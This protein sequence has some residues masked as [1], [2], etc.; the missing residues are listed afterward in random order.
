MVCEGGE[1]DGEIQSVHESGKTNGGSAA[2]IVVAGEP[3]S[4]QIK[5]GG[6]DRRCLPLKS[7][8]HQK[9]RTLCAR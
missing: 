7:P 5:R 4:T 6:M 1:N 2:Q 3:E 8:R 9:T